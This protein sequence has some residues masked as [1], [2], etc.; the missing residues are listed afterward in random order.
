MK[1]ANEIIIVRSGKSIDLHTKQV[2]IFVQKRGS[3]KA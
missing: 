2:L 1:Y 3:Q